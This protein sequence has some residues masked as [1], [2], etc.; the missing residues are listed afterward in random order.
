MV[1][2]VIFNMRLTWHTY[3]LPSNS[4]EQH[5]LRFCTVVGGKFQTTELELATSTRL[6]LLHDPLP[7]HLLWADHLNE[8]FELFL[9]AQHLVHQP[10]VDTD[11][12]WSCAPH[13][14]GSRKFWWESFE[15]EPPVQLP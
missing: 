12:C 7:V 2:L 8:E 10:L 14:R 1:P 5:H 3:M 9:Q 4:G 15:T 11:L 13:E 6:V